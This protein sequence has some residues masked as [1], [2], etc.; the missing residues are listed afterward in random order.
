M[1]NANSSRSGAR[2]KEAIM[3]QDILERDYSSQAI[4]AGEGRS[5]QAR[6]LNYDES[7]AD[8]AA[9]RGEP[10]N[11]TWSMAA[12]VVYEGIVAAMSVHGMPRDT[13]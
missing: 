7:K 9:F 3:E 6:P 4:E 1:I 13:R 8:E 12:Q 11:S 2:T 10:F 5:R